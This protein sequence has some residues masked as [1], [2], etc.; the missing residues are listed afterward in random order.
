MLGFG[1]VEGIIPKEPSVPL[2]IQLNPALKPAN[3]TIVD[4]V[5]HAPVAMV[6][7]P[8][9][10]DYWLLRVPLTVKQAIVGFPKFGT[11]GIG[12]QVEAKDWNTNLPWS[13]NSGDIAHHIRRNKGSRAIANATVVEAI[14]LIQETIA[15]N[16]RAFGVE[17]R[18][19]SLYHKQKR[20]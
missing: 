12:Y 1:Y 7:P 19:W 11:I 13:S 9:N 6:T 4:P 10:E 2:E 8:I 16:P 5:T 18:S 20:G 17:Q 15:A 14:C 3:D